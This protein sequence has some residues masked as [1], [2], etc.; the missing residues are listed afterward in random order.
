MIISTPSC[1]PPSLPLYLLSCLPTRHQCQALRNIRDQQVTPGPQLNGVYSLE[2]DKHGAYDKRATGME[3]TSSG[4][5]PGV[6]FFFSKARPR[7]SLLLKLQYL[8]GPHD[9]SYSHLILENPGDGPLRIQRQN[10][11]QPQVTIP[12]ALCYSPAFLALLLKCNKR[13]SEEHILTLGWR[14]TI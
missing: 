14:K 11:S 8:Q 13:N 1:L 12:H 4:N 7:S 6:W 9:D 5:N 2:R 10:A 3:W